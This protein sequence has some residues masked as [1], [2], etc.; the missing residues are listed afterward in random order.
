MQW[1]VTARPFMEDPALAFD[2]I[3]RA[4]IQGSMMKHTDVLQLPGVAI[5][6]DGVVRY[7]H[8]SAKTDDLPPTSEI[9]ERLDV[10][11]RD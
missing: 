3:R 5:L 9:L 8:R 11:D 10:L 1:D 7:L 2:R 4:S 6:A